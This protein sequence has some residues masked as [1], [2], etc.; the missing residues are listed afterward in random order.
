MKQ[1]VLS[2]FVYLL[3]T[4]CGHPGKTQD[5]TGRWYSE[6]SSRIYTVYKKN[7]YF[8]GVLTSST[9]KEDIRGTLILD[10]VTSRRKKCRFAGAIHSADNTTITRVKMCFLKNSGNVL[11]LKLKR[12]FFLPVKIYWHKQAGSTV[13][14]A[15]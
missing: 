12:M 2:S 5:I 4:F 15:P 14:A 13:N 1:I 9:R 6:D 3:C 8:E 10:R 11:C 7:N